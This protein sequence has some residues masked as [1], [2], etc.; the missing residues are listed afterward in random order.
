VGQKISGFE[1][2]QAVFA[3]PSGRINLR[4][5]KASGSEEGEGLKSALYCKRGKEVEQWLY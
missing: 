4:E 2:S 3:R 5:G 1:G